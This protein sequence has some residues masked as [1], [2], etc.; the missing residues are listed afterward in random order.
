[1]LP[2]PMAASMENIVRVLRRLS[3]RCY[4]ASGGA[5]GEHQ[6]WHGVRGRGHGLVGGVTRGAAVA[7]AVASAS[8]SSARPPA[9]ATAVARWRPRRGAPAARRLRRAEIGRGGASWCGSMRGPPRRQRR[10]CAAREDPAHRGRPRHRGAHHPPG[11]REAV[12]TGGFP[13][14]VVWKPLRRCT[15]Q[16]RA[17][18]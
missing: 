4:R 14:L 15:T 5:S 9:W 10:L 16:G 13:G 3:R 17:P 12:A 1:M 8:F 6:H 2:S 18:G 11:R 7:A